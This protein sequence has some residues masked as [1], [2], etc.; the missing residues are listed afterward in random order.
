MFGGVRQGSLL[1]IL[2]KTSEG[3]ELKVAQ[4]EEFTTPQDK[5]G[6]T[7]IY[8]N[9]QDSEL[10]IKVKCGEEAMNLTK[11]P[12][13]ASIGYCDN[14]I[15]S[16]TRE[17]M[18]AEVEA[19]LRTSRQT[20]ENVPYHEQMVTNCEAMLRTLNPHLAK[21]KEQ[22]EKI[23]LLE[24]KMSNIEGTLVDIQSMLSSALSAAKK[25]KK[26]E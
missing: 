6:R 26:E 15:V 10:S 9:P 18:S 16:D 19:M 24:S 3:A 22:E 11:L 8:A 17:A 2:S 5:Y 12:A 7:G 21:E 14:L 25:P 23:G 1:Y 4:V 20:L 13:H